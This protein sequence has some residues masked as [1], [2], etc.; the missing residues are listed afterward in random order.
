LNEHKIVG[1][2]DVEVLAVIDEVAWLDLI[3]GGEEVVFAP[4]DCGEM[5]DGY[6]LTRSATPTMRRRSDWRAILIWLVIT[7]Q[8]VSTIQ[9]QNIPAPS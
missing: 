3:D 5:R 8:A 4:V 2:L 7:M 1:A 9:S 6:L